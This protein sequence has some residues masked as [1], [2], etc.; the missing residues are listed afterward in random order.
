MTTQELQGLLSTGV[1]ALGKNKVFVQSALFAKL[2]AA[3]PAIKQMASTL[4]AF[5]DADQFSKL[6]DA[7]L[8]MEAV[9]VDGGQGDRM[10]E[11]MS[12]LHGRPLILDLI[13]KLLIR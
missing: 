5:D 7:V 10:V 2:K 4:L 9:M 3:A 8:S 1:E 12:K 11:I 13:A 6:F